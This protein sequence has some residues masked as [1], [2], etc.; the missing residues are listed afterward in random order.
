MIFMRKDK[1]TKLEKYIDEKLEKLIEEAE[2]PRDI[3]SI[4]ELLE[5]RLD[6]E[7]KKRFKVS[8][9]TVVLALANLTGIVL[10]L[11]HEELN[12]IT[13]KAFNLLRRV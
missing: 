5:K 8:P 1:R 11:K 7:D 10:V 12:V 6:I 2:D 4:L 9:D 3:K 13:G